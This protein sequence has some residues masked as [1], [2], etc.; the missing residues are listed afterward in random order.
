MNNALEELKGDLKNCNSLN[1]IF[2]AVESLYD[3]EAQ[4]GVLAKAAIINKLPTIIK[5]AGL[6]PHE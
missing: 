1:D 2:N 5:V 6:K 3:T 4:L